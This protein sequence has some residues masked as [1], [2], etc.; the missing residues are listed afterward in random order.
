MGSQFSSGAFVD[1]K[2]LV[3]LSLVQVRS[4][5]LRFEKCIDRNFEEYTFMM[6]RH[7]QWTLRLSD[8]RTYNLFRRFDTQSYGRIPTLDLFGA[9][10]LAAESDPGS[11]VHA[12]FALV[13]TN[14]DDLISEVELT[15]AITCAVRGFS[16]LKGNAIPTE[17]TIR[18]IVTT[19]FKRCELSESRE[20]SQSE[21]TAFALSDDLC[22]TYLASLDTEVSAADSSKVFILFRQPTTIP[23]NVSTSS[24]NP[25][26][27]PNPNPALSLYHRWSRNAH[28][29][30]RR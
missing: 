30:S 4:L 6:K 12:L 8:R 3:G 11:K 5:Y 13:D 23:H 18:T 21:V 1:V 28:C 7:F 14:K 24:S 16:R 2:G 9:L 29:L 19:A 26:P 20:I 22:R 17:K 10:T 27:N 15:I 25:N